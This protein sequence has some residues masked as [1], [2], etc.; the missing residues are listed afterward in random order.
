MRR[1]LRVWR[2]V[3]LLLWH[4]R[5]VHRYELRLPDGVITMKVWPDDSI[6]LRDANEEPMIII[7][8]AGSHETWI[9]V[10][11]EQE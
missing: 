11:G 2:D 10:M 6:T 7:Y 5:R 9:T 1:W 8:Q 3:L 4:R